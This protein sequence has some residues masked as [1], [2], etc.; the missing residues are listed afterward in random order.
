M[1][2]RIKSEAVTIFQRLRISTRIYASIASLLVL[3]LLAIAIACVGLVRLKSNVLRYAEADQ[4]ATMINRIDRDI[5]ELQR[6]VLVFAASGNESAPDRIRQVGQSLRDQIE[7]ATA[8]PHDE[9][10]SYRLSEMKLRLETYLE[11]FPEVI[12]DRQTRQTLVGE[13]LLELESK[14][15]PAFEQLKTLVAGREQNTLGT[16]AEPNRRIPATASDKDYLGA[17]L[18]AI[19]GVRC[20][21]SSNR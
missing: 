7:K 9:E 14:T 8:F 16:N 6:D 19:L 10:T 11:N 18:G 13:T 21:S 3:F 5:I 17:I 2:E 15:R 20:L 12:E 4:L 1:D